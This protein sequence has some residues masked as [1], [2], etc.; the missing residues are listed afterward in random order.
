MLS[1]NLVSFECKIASELYKEIESALDEHEGVEIRY[2]VAFVLC[3]ITS[4][5]KGFFPQK[6]PINGRMYATKTTGIFGLIV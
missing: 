2:I 1:L 5:H 6:Y 4:N 3:P